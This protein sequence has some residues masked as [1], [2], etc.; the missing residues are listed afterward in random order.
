MVREA[1]YGTGVYTS[2]SHQF[3]PPRAWGPQ[4][5]PSGALGV[6]QRQETCGN[7]TSSWV[8]VLRRRRANLWFGAIRGLGVWKET[9]TFVVEVPMMVRTTEGVGEGSKT[10]GERQP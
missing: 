9:Q 6:L 10:Y 5:K 8:E 1:G 4:R 2:T 3:L 7:S